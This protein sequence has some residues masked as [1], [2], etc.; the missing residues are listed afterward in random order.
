MAWLHGLHVVPWGRLEVLFDVDACAFNELLILK[1]VVIF[2]VCQAG[3]LT[4]RA[5]V[6]VCQ[7]ACQDPWPI[8]LAA[9]AVLYCA[10]PLH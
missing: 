9:E 2:E 4:T 10:V 7:A 3:K 5:S 1:H 8:V 6:Y